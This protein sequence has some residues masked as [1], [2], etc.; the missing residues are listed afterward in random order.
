MTRDWTLSPS[1]PAR[2][3]SLTETV[4]EMVGGS[5]GW[6][7]RASVTSMAHRV[8]ATVAFD[9]PAMATM[10]PASEPSSTGLTLQAAEGQHLGDAA[11]FDFLAVAVQGVDRH[12][13][14]GLAALDTAGQHATQE[15][16]AF[17]QHAQHLERLVLV[18]LN[19]GFGGTWLT[20]RSNRGAR[21]SLGVFMSSVAQ[22]ARPEA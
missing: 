3:L 6:A 19:L 7:G 2:G 1:R 16:V 13:G 21:V 10:S 11:A 5:I 15:G 17:D 14:N 4:I 8:S 9:R 12:A 20:I 22:P 18:L